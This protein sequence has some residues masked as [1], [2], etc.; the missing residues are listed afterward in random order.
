MPGGH[1]TE[2][3]SAGLTGGPLVCLARQRFGKRKMIASPQ[4]L[5][6]NIR[7]VPQR[8]VDAALTAALQE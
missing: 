6:L 3:L 2:V 4:R 1:A 7:E 5:W 8:V